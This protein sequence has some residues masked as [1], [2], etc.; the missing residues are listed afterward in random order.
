MD[1]SHP[2]FLLAIVTFL[3]VVAAAIWNLVATR[4]QQKYGRHTTGIGGPD[5]PLK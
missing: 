5:D 3:L 1:M 2:L 4:R